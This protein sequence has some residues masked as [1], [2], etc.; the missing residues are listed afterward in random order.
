[1]K[2]NINDKKNAKVI[3]LS[4][5]TIIG[6][7]FLETIKKFVRKDVHVKKQGEISLWLESLS[8]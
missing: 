2:L 6:T 8:F 1:L 5:D 7:S 3:V 4:V